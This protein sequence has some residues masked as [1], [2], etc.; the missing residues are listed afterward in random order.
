MINT[1]LT[2]TAIA[3]TPKTLELMWLTPLFGM[4]MVF[5][6]LTILWGVLAIFKMIFAKPEP[7]K[8]EAPKAPVAPV[9]PVAEP[10]PVAYSAGDDELIA[11]ITAAVAAYISSEEPD[12]YTGGFRVVSFRRAN[13]GRS[14][15]AK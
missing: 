8:K 2:A 7:K 4:A 11:L 13:G 12:A 1:A 3:L 15:N 6:V 5:A 14:W 10:E 9:A